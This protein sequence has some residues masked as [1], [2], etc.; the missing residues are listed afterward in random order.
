MRSVPKGTKGSLII[1]ENPGLVLGSPDPI[2][3]D[4]LNAIQGGDPCLIEQRAPWNTK[5]NVSLAQV[6]DGNTHDSIE[7]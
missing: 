7:I 3:N 4:A 1:P 5:I 6:S 2:W